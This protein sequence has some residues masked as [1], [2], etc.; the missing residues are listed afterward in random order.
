MFM[1][2]NIDNFI[3]SNFERMGMLKG[4]RWYINTEEDKDI[5]SAGLFKPQ[6]KEFGNKKVFCG[7]HYGE[8]VGYFLAINAGTDVCRA[9][10]AHLS[11]YF[12]NIH[13]LRN[14]ARAEE[15][16]GCIT[17]SKLRANQELEHGRVIVDIFMMDNHEKYREL[18]KNE[19]E[20]DKSDNIEVIL[21]AI[22]HRIRTF[23]K[24]SDYSQEEIDKKVNENKHKAIEMMV[25][26][27]LYGNNDRHDE[28]WAMVRDRSG[29]ELELYPLYDNERVLGLYENQEYIEDVLG[30]NN[31]KRT[32]SEEEI[33]Q[34]VEKASEEGLFSRMRVPG[35]EKRYSNYK[36]VLEYLMKNHKE[37]TVEI[38]ERHLDKNTPHIVQM[39]LLS[40]DGLPKPYLEF[41]KIMYK[42]R[43]EYAEKLYEQ[44]KIIEFDTNSKKQNIDRDE[45]EIG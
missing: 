31:T 19:R 23:Y 32:F 33:K 30:I 3:P 9:E 4:K 22:E 37:Y 42:S 10:L 5:N 25:Y 15:K 20:S 17:Y 36:D 39:Y 40:C 24:S 7:N 38:L 27:C 14:S 43:Y 21:N 18:A 12:E 44:N 16:N 26:D 8:V 34:R 2:R 1:F 28:N 13:K 29:N 11:K 41:Q 6:R 45:R 35:E